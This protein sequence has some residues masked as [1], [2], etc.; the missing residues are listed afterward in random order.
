M[1]DYLARQNGYR[2]PLDPVQL[3]TV[4]ELVG[5]TKSD[6]VLEVGCATGRLLSRLNLL[7]DHVV[8]VDINKHSLQY[9]A[10]DSSALQADATK[11]PFADESF[12]LVI[13]NHVIEH[14]DNP[15]I[16]TRELS[17]VTES[18]GFIFLTYP[19]EPIRGLF[20]SV[21]SM[22]MYGHPFGGRSIHKHAVRPPAFDVMESVLSIAHVKSSI[23]PLPMPQFFTLLQK[24]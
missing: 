13:S 22:R 20:A 4:K 9:V 14:T 24:D 16:F 6:R 10:P 23:K 12:D 3:K 21:A 5:N 2:R 15:A 1:P 17:R 11:L 18:G 19:F 8:G 7:V